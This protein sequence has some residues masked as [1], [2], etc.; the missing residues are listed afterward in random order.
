MV[1]GD[2]D[3]ELYSES[4]GSGLSWGA[5]LFLLHKQWPPWLIIDLHYTVVLNPNR[6]RPKTGTTLPPQ[7]LSLIPS[8]NPP[9]AVLNDDLF[10]Y[11]LYLSLNADVGEKPSTLA[12][13]MIP[14][15]Q[16]KK[17]KFC[18]LKPS[19]SP[20]YITGLLT[21]ARSTARIFC[22]LGEPDCSFAVTR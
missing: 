5:I 17:K 9:I 1:S 2:G 11:T 16:T 21:L 19:S 18:V 7:Y 4:C 20:G 6:I 12:M 8:A 22:N 14:N 10:F 3:F 13:L 15:L